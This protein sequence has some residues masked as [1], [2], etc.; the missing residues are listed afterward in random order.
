ML[1]LGAAFFN[2]LS[3]YYVVA[4]RTLLV[5]SHARARVPMIPQMRLDRFMELANITS[6]SLDDHA[7][8]V[9]PSLHEIYSY[10]CLY[11]HITVSRALFIIRNITSCAIQDW[12]DFLMPWGHR[13]LAYGPT[14]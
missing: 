5:D 3:T 1:S 2:S 7:I 14:P 10:R 6:T 11:Q 9:F 12:W 13:L 4:L 8:V